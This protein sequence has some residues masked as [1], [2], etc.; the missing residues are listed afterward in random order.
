M[1]YG[2]TNLENL[3]PGENPNLGDQ[4]AYT[5]ERDNAAIGNKVISSPE[6][7][8]MP[9]PQPQVEYG[10][11]VSTMPAAPVVPANPGEATV[12][13]P[14]IYD[15]TAI[16]TSGDHLDKTAVGEIKKLEDKLSQDEDLNSF[17]EE[18]RELTS[19]NL[20]NS[21]NRELGETKGGAA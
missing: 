7:F 10:E 2:H 11:I 20:K 6:D 1:D 5:P 13:Q 19:V 15:K 16:R 9:M 21:Y 4:W 14:A 12:S 3:T 8:G 18:A 17:Y